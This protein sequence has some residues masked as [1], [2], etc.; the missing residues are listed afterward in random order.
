MVLLTLEQMISLFSKFLPVLPDPSG[1]MQEPSFPYSLSLAV[2]S[3]LLLSKHIGHICASGPLHWLFLMAGMLSPWRPAWLPPHL[4]PVLAH[5][6]S[7]PWGSLILIN[8]DPSVW[9]C[10]SL[11]HSWCPLSLFSFFSLHTSPIPSYHSLSQLLYLSLMV[12]IPFWEWEFCP[13]CSVSI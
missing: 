12:C 3:S 9:K 8:L 13:F 1:W 10:S 4:P 5:M 6:S 2:L 7:S 11:L